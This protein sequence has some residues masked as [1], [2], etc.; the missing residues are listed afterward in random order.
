L[1][2]PS[3]QV[4]ILLL[5]SDQRLNEYGLRTDTLLLVTLNP[6]QGT[7]SLTSLPRD[8]YIYIPGYTVQRINTA[9][10]FGGFETLAM[11]FEYNLGVRPDH[12]ALI[13][14]WSFSQAVDSLGGVDVNV[15]MPFSDHRDGY[16]DYYVPAGM[17][18]MD[19]A[20]ALWYVRARYTTSDFDRG[21]RQKEVLTA[22][23]N[24]V[25][26]LDGISR[27]S[28]LY[29]IYAQNV[30]T[31]LTFEDIAP[32][33]PLAAQLADT[34]RISSYAIGPQQVY[35]FRNTQGSA[36]LCPNSSEDLLAVMRQALGIP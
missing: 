19:G 29:Q 32:L 8:L 20:T 22:A 1:A 18:H 10:G 12:Y 7:A 17:V 30:T 23:F 33:L 15:G 31:D 3:D 28:E 11:T 35:D 36:V 16:G 13:N 2:K 21:R 6:S 27:A 24:K 4:N 26:S 34:S 9:Y 14:F 25:L 5:G